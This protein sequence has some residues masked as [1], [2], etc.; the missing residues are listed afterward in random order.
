MNSSIDA[1][2]TQ[3]RSIGGIDHR[4]YLHLRDISLQQ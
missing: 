3:Q 4:I 1:A 2:T